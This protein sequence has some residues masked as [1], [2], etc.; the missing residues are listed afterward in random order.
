MSF[1][2]NKQPFRLR[3]HQNTT[4]PKRSIL[5]HVSCITAVTTAAASCLYSKLNIS[6]ENGVQCY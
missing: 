6:L 5:C 2:T 4:T 1:A 3:Q